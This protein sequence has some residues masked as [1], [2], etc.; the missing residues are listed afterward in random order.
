MGIALKWFILQELQIHTRLSAGVSKSSL[1]F[2]YSQALRDHIVAPLVELGVDG[3]DQAVSR[4]G[5]YTLRRVD[6]DGLIELTKWPLKPDPLSVVESKIK[7]AF[8]RKL[9][10][11]GVVLPYSITTTVSRKKERSVENLMNS[12]EEEGSDEDGDNI[13][14]DASIK[15]MKPKVAQKKDI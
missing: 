4:M 7:A 1:A 3:V 10:K 6:L 15:V 2:E 13:V 9:N 14:K 8:T 12:E 11:E 5:E